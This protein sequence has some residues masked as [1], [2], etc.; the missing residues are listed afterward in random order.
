MNTFSEMN[1]FLRFSIALT[2]CLLLFSAC[3]NNSRNNSR[4]N[5]IEE[6]GHNTEAY[7]NDIPP[8]PPIPPPPQNENDTTELPEHA[9]TRH[10]YGVLHHPTDLGGRTIR[11]ASTGEGISFSGGGPE[12]DP[13]TAENY[14]IDRLVWDNARRVRHSFNFELEDVLFP[15]DQTSI[16]NALQTFA[17][18]GNPAADVAL[19][20][21]FS[22][23]SAIVD[24]IILPLDSLYLPNSDV[25]GPQVFGRV[26]SE[27]LEERWSFTHNAPQL[28]LGALWVNLDIINAI[29]APNPV[30][31]YN[32][33]QWTWDAW[34]EIMRLATRDTTGGSNINQFGI[35]DSPDVIIGGLIASN[36]GRIISENFEWD[37]GSP[38][39][40]EAI[41]FAEI[42]FREGLTERVFMG[43]NALREGNTAFFFAPLNFLADNY[44]PFEFAIVPF[45]I[46]PGN[47]SG[48]TSIGIWGNGLV[49]PQ[50]SVWNQA[51]IL[52]VI[53]EFWAWPHDAQELIF[54]ASLGW[55]QNLLPTDGDLHRMLHAGQH[56]NFCISWMINDL[57]FAYFNF[58]NYFRAQEM[59]AAQVVDMYRASQQ[60]IIDNFFW[61]D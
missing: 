48:N 17:M 61:R 41:E 53:E 16:F 38:N 24:D 1:F 29:G 47:T 21:P 14:R 44:L 31:L 35:S 49:F 40:L 30:D 36:D 58:A 5:S 56:A 45:P 2:L 37:M 7:T 25:L 50:G 26:E 9:Q 55:A 11:V 42:I 60:E 46:G 20:F 10:T 32:R 27:L 39:A 34:L 18:A 54:E 28:G 3:S 43:P 15:Q 4:N 23:L 8:P 51:E 6:D 12:P 22:K 19:L 33:G 59:T 57:V 52:M 13:A